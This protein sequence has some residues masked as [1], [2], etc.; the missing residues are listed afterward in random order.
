MSK[1]FAFLTGTATEDR[2][3]DKEFNV[4]TT[5]KCE[6]PAYAVVV[7]SEIVHI[8]AQEMD[9]DFDDVIDMIMYVHYERYEQ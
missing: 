7:A 3:N 8:V 5:Y 2:G 4:H 9:C 1:V 6:D